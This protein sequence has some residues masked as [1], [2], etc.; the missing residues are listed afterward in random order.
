MKQNGYNCGDRGKSELDKWKTVMRLKPF[1]CMLFK[2]FYTF[3]LF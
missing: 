1:C 3:S 2:A